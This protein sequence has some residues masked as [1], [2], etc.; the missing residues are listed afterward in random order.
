[1]IS[2]EEARERI[3]AALPTL[4][5]ESVSLAQALGR[6][7]ARDV[8]SRLTQPP[9]DVSAM[10][11]YAVIAADLAQVPATLTVIGEAPAGNAFPD[12]VGPG[13]AVRIFTGGPLPE[14][15]DTIVIQ[16]NVERDDDRITVN[17]AVPAGT[18]VRPAGLDFSAGESLI[19]SGALFNVRTLGL[20]AAMNVPWV[21]V[22]RK[23]RVAVLAT[24]DELVLPGDPMAANQIISSNGLALAAFVSAF[25]GEPVNL[26]IAPDDPA[27]LDALIAAAA[28]ADLIV[29]SGG[30]SVGDHDL[31]S[32]V[33]GE[34]RME[35]DFWKIAMR[36]GKP[37]IFGRIDGTPLLGVPG[38]PVSA[39]VCS[40]VFLRPALQHML[41]LAEDPDRDGQAILE[42]PLPKN[43][44]RQDYLRARLITSPD[45]ATRVRPFDRQDSSMLRTLSL[46]DCLIVRP[47]F[48]EAA[49]AGTSVDIL[50]FFGG[51]MRV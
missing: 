41:G 27:A 12:R 9:A 1:M 26:G 44:Q 49:E 15:S 5:A 46:A 6:V 23:P 33:L 28:G 29:T 43:D 50:P 19:P 17:E 32:K 30:A 34:G 22:R 51:L 42:T 11:G 48:A 21:S 2:V 10:D 47:P 16:E 37:L 7:A 45:G 3:L 35:V 24:G 31:V 36:P 4:P 40:L 39:I 20:A 13:Q 8:V 18:Y 25:G 14:G 38:N